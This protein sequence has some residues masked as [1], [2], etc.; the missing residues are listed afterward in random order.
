[1][2]AQGFTETGYLQWTYISPQQGLHVILDFILASLILLIIN[3]WTVFGDFTIFVL[4]SFLSMY[5]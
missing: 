5:Y 1:M 3:P 2:R 4:P